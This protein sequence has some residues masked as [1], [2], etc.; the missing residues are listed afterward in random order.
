MI[1]FGEN[2][3]MFWLKFKNKSMCIDDTT[4]IVAEVTVAKFD[5]EKQIS[6]SFAWTMIV[7]ACENC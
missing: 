1:T 3:H 5:L 6:M 7:L 2:A 4:F